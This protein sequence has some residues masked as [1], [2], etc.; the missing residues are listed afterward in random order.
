MKILSF[1]YEL[2]RKLK[3]KI[4]SFLKMMKDTQPMTVY[5][6]AIASNLDWSLLHGIE[7]GPIML[8]VEAIKHSQF[9]QNKTL[10]AI[11]FRLEKKV[12]DH[13]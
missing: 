3:E 13:A 11:L 7:D 5:V 9:Y 4:R 12:P 10:R 2:D 8:L 6:E 1:T